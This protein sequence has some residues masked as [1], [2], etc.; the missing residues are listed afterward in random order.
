MIVQVCLC[1]V[2]KIV[3]AQNQREL[4][5]EKSHPRFGEDY[6]DVQSRH[7]QN[8]NKSSTDSKM[9]SRI[10]TDKYAS[11]VHRNGN[12]SSFLQRKRAVFVI[13]NEPIC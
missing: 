7:Y 11:N 5:V 13:A 4:E 8:G 9:T 12:K 2:G 3:I 10:K 6:F 1:C